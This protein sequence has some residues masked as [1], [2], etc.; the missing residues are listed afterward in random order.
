[1]IKELKKTKSR[2]AMLIQ[3]LVFA[4]IAAVLLAG[5]VGWAAISIKAARFS[6]YREKSF[7]IAEAGIDY[8][9]WHLA[10]S[11]TDYEDGTGAAGPYVHAFNDR[12]GNRIGEFQLEIVPPA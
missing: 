12:D 8:Y 1:M 7:Q 2:G 6:L 4:S 3:I 10:H 11:P 5:L 9:R